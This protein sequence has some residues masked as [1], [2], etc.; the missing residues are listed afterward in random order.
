V[1]LHPKSG[2]KLASIVVRHGQL[3][4]KARHNHDRIVEVDYITSDGANRVGADVPYLAAALIDLDPRRFG[5]L[6]SC[7]GVGR[8][9]AIICERRGGW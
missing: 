5:H 1:R 4:L 7:G 8:N 9:R 2:E 3:A 6:R